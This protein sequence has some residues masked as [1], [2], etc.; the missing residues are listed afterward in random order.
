MVRKFYITDIINFFMKKGVDIISGIFML[1][2]AVG[3]LMLSIVFGLLNLST[4]SHFFSK[5]TGYNSLIVTFG[6][7]S[8]FL[9]YISIS[10]FLNKRW[11][12]SISLFIY[13]L[14]VLF[15]SL[16]LFMSLGS[17]IFSTFLVIG[18]VIDILLFVF[19]LRDFIK[20][21]N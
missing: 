19:V 6:F 11:A 7:I 16:L 17:I 5:V 8:F 2:F 21:K 10:I 13:G 20:S 9:F 15:L 14:L 3:F 18:L 4:A 12:K 1:L